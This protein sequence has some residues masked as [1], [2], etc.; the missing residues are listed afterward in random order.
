MA[1]ESICI[2]NE[3]A[4]A[5]VTQNGLRTFTMQ[6]SMYAS[7]SRNMLPLNFNLRQRYM[8]FLVLHQFVRHAYTP[9]TF[10]FFTFATQPHLLTSMHKNDFYVGVSK[11][12][13]IANITTT[14][15]G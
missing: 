5:T 14:F 7:I 1:Y 4:P 9:Y 3:G 11:L 6:I 13:R 8:H 12:N 10:L 2:L 15:F